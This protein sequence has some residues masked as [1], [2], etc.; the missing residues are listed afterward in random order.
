MVGKSLEKKALGYVLLALGLV[1]V[2]LIFL[3]KNLALMPN[4]DNVAEQL[5]AY[6]LTGGAVA[7]LILWDW[8]R[9]W[10]C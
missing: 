3:V 5:K 1:S 7:T 2:V 9:G 4:V 10:C 6:K 8:W